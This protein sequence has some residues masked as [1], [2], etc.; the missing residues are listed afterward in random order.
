GGDLYDIVRPLLFH[1][2]QPADSKS[3]DGNCAK[4]SK[5]PTKPAREGV[6]KKSLCSAME[7]MR[8]RHMKSSYS[9]LTSLLPPQN[10]HIKSKKPVKDV[11]SE[12]I[13]Y[14]RHLQEKVVRLS[15]T[16]DEMRVKINETFPVVK[17][18]HVCSHV[19]VT[20]DTMRGQMVLSKL[21]VAVEEQGLQVITASSFTTRNKLTHTLHCE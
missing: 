20:T 12:A 15:K 9:E 8:R 13:G 18:D 19:L 5:K 11:V 14:I 16:R 6:E 17:V 21:I 7:M 3:T 10:K 1:N 2:S 4:F